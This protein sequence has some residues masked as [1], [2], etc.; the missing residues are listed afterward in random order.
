MC[1]T[2]IYMAPE[3]WAGKIYTEKVDIWS[4]GIMLYML[5]NGSSPFAGIKSANAL[6][7]RMK[8]G[9][10]F[11]S[12]QSEV[13][14][15][16]KEGQYVLSRMLKCNPIERPGA[17][18]LLNEKW[19]A[20][21]LLAPIPESIASSIIKNVKVYKSQN[22]F[23]KSLVAYLSIHFNMETDKKYIIKLF[24]EID[25]DKNGKISR[26]EFSKSIVIK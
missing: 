20:D 2:P 13:K 4:C 21:D 11:E 19:F 14:H 18:T 9:Q 8:K 3:I 22:I 16:S 6:K 26:A 25:I 5:L 1:G 24:E 15:L 17:K 12:I 10:I 7:R 23:T